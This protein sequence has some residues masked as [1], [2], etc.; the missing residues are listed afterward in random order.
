MINVGHTTSVDETGLAPFAKSTGKNLSLGVGES[1]AYFE[2][3]SLAIRHT[4]IGSELDAH[5]IILSG[6]VFDETLV[7]EPDSIQGNMLITSIQDSNPTFTGGLL[8][9]SN[10]MMNNITIEGITLQGEGATDVAFSIEAPAGISDLTIRE[11]TLDGSLAAGNERSGIIAS[12][13][14][15]IITI[16]S[17]QFNDLTGA[18]ALTST[19]DG[20]DP[21][22]GQI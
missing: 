10:Y 22:E 8:L 3:P 2:S 18:Y 14:G 15:G 4:L 19:P 17:N 21:G 13:L 11:V 1:T 20:L 16:D 12:G 6:G 7:I 5:N 9:Q